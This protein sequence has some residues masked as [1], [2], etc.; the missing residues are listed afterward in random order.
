[1][2]AKKSCK[3]CPIC[4]QSGGSLTER[5]VKY[6]IN[7]QPRRKIIT[8]SDAWDYGGR[9]NL[10]LAET[11][12]LY[13]PT[14]SLSHRI[15]S[16]TYDF[17]KRFTYHN[18][19]ETRLFESKFLKVIP[20]SL[21]AR[22]KSLRSIYDRSME[23][24]DGTPKHIRDPIHV[25]L[26]QDCGVATKAS[27][28]LVFAACICLALKDLFAHLSSDNDY[29][30]VRGMYTYFSLFQ[31]ITDLRVFGSWLDYFRMNQ[32][33]EKYGYYRASKLARQV[34]NLCKH[35]E[36]DKNKFIEMTR[37]QNSISWKCPEC[38][39]ADPIVTH[40][41]VTH[42]KQKNQAIRE[43][44][45]DCVQSIPVFLKSLD[46][47]VYYLKSNPSIGREFMKSFGY[48]E[49]MAE[50]GVLLCTKR[51]FWKHYDNSK[52][53]K[54][55]WCSLSTGENDRREK[56]RSALVNTCFSSS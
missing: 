52:K 11:I 49:L 13:P 16:S 24:Y 6:T 55:R 39:G 28:S 27:V 19:I 46:S 2:P 41:S 35:C 56:N 4:H 38:G 32:N 8:L 40:F 25:T 50:R 23:H 9:V 10:R 5:C 48:Y 7:I 44:A 1:V 34:T 42:L 54:I 17:W 12:M 15:A 43:K 37:E 29:P 47:L 33:V 14:N 22:M 53:S 36:Q 20:K 3:M 21:K 26:P 51:R 31:D 30:M 45:I 18:D